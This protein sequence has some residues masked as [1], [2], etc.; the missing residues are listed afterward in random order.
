MINLR[1]PLEILGDIDR[2][3][4]T[5]L[6]EVPP[7]EPSDRIKTLIQTVKSLSQHK[8]PKPPEPHP[9][10]VQLW[11]TIGKTNPDKL[12]NRAIRYLSWEAEIAI[13]HEFQAI[14]LTPKR[15]SAW[16]LQGFVRSVHRRWNTV[17][18]YSLNKVA[19]AI[20]DYKGRNPLIEK[21]KKEI[22]YVLNR[23]APRNLAKET[24][25]SS[26]TW[27]ITASKWGI[28]HDTEFGNEVLKQCL[29][30]ASEKPL[31]AEILSEQIVR[32]ILPS[33]CWMS[34]SFKKATQQ[35]LLA[36]PEMSQ[37]FIE[38]LKNF[39]LSDSR[40][41]DPRLPANVN[42]WIGIS[43]NARELLIQWLSAED[44]Q[45]FFDHVLPTRSDPHGRKPFWLKYKDKV[46]R[47][48][49][50]LS[51]YDET[52]WRVNSVTKGKSNYGRMGYGLDTSAFMLD[53][54]SVMVVEFSKVGNAVYVYR[55]RDIP[56]L[57]DSFWSNSHFPLHKLKQSAKCEER[58]IHDRN[59]NWQSKM[60]TL[61]AQ[62][63]VQPGNVD[64][65]AG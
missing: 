46:K 26:T 5:M 39:V 20:M 58:I 12:N 27:E 30:F 24:M 11:H 19:S 51:E 65:Y 38:L 2:L 18:G 60:R 4:K 36:S 54:G 21:W 40:L 34:D 35:L 23:D 59:Q 25:T 3:N 32:R 55:H 7:T 1:T 45:L 41:L 56:N 57:I 14:A 49:P 33:R 47:S 43:D 8:N 15:I 17:N 44:I 13:S 48:R 42:N 6:H 10:Y 64:R 52:Q 50:I 28:E 31:E 16:S 9:D 61:L 29:K 62:F 22:S 63:G 53:F 37:Q